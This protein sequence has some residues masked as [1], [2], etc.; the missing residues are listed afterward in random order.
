MP[1]AS[2]PTPRVGVLLAVLA[3]FASSALLLGG[4]SSTSDGSTAPPGA[5]PPATPTPGPTSAPTAPSE[6]SPT[7][8]PTP[9]VFDSVAYGYRATFPGGLLAVP[10][11]EAQQRW[12]G[13]AV[14][15]SDGPYTDR[16]YLPGN[17]LL[18]VY[19]ASTDLDL[20][21]YAAEGQ[22]LKHEWHD[23]PET[24]EEAVETTFGGQPAVLHSFPCGGL[25]VFSVFAVR[26]GYG[27]V[28]NQLTPPVDVAADTAAFLELLAGWIWLE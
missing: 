4:C 12:D 13:E 20:G 28:V 24:P 22:R 16:F 21:D 5:S 27:L 19:G 11:S 14:V 2:S 10:P 17:R 23:C 7:P 1:P 26:D 3:L 6:P 8:A 25:R 9:T 18:F 15:N